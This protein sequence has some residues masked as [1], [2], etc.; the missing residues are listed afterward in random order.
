MVNEVGLYNTKCLDAQLQAMVN[1]RQFDSAL[2]S[3]M[4]DQVKVTE[5][6]TCQ[7]ACKHTL[8]DSNH[9]SNA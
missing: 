5:T 9:N 7:I 8:A 2:I 1:I 6:G 3:L 4:V